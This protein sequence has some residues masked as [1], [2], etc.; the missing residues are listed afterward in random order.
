MSETIACQMPDVFRAI[1]SIAGS[2]L[3]S[4]RSCAR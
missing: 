3:G 2:L 1:G 4:T